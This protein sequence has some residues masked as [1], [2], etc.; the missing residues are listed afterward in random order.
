MDL[1][2]M[3]KDE[4]VGLVEEMECLLIWLEDKFGRGK[5]FKKGRKEEVMEILGRGEAISIADIAA[6]IGIK[7]RNVSSQ[8]SYLRDDGIEIIK[9]G[10]GKGLLKLVV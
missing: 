5:K 2:E 6:E 8:L 3:K 10:R 4:L 9:V 7:S 1:K